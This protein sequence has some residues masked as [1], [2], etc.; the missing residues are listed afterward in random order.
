MKPNPVHAT[1][2]YLGGANE[3]RA[4]LAGITFLDITGSADLTVNGLADWFEEHVVAGGYMPR[5]SVL[6]EP[7]A[8]SVALRATGA[9]L[10]HAV[11]DLPRLASTARARVLAA[12]RGLIST[13]SD[14]R[15]LRAA[16]FCN[17]VRRE[18]SRWVARPEPTAPVSG[19]VLS[20][21]ATAI[22]SERALFDHMLCVCDT[23][24]SVSFDPTPAMRRLCGAHATRTSGTQHKTPPRGARG[25][26][27]G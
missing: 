17:R 20:L 13:P 23:C 8:G 18:E 27:N 10:E 25:A 19:I 21:F 12:M 22:L 16:I 26:A 4:L 1:L 7:P 9:A 11:V 5:L 3:R 2:P 15:F 24:G 14:D 6:L